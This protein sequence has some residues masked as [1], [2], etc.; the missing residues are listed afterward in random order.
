MLKTEKR[1]FDTKLSLLSL[2]LPIL[3]EQVLRSLMGTVNTSV[4]GHYSTFAVS[5]VGVANQIMNVVNVLFN[6]ISAGTIVLLNQ[7]LGAN[8]KEQ[9]GHVAMNA[10]T[11]G[12]LLGAALSAVLFMCANPFM[13]LIG[14]D[15]N[16][17]SDAVIYLKIVGGCAVFNAASSMMSGIF[18]CYGNAKVPMFVVMVNNILNLFGTI[19]VV[20]RPFET[21]LHGVGGVAIIRAGSEFF[22]LCLMIFLLVRS[23]FGLKINNLIRLRVDYLKKIIGIGVMSGMEGLS[24]T[25]GQVVT[26][27]FITGLGALAISTKTYVQNIDYYAYVIGQS[28]GAATQIIAGHMIGAGKKDEALRYVNRNWW[29]VAISNVFFGVVMYIFSPYIMRIFTSDPEIIAHS[30]VLFLI[31]IAIHAARSFNHTHNAGLRSAG[32][33]FYP[34]I[35]AVSSIWL[36]NVGLGYVFSVALGLGI[37]GL[38]LGQMVDEWVRGLIT[39]SLWQSKK[40]QKNI[41]IQSVAEEKQ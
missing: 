20:Y 28:I 16:L 39:M 10:I 24:Y 35:I 41:A 18:R 40:W 11:S 1:G 31:D 14:L 7:M 21:P 17:L 37:A 29:F 2:A 4:L 25:F 5:S 3:V 27:A 33:V 6:M 38:W 26:T 8:K 36:C 13:K 23:K 12:A 19:L 30:R 15:D 9:A 22:G 32:Y 34:M